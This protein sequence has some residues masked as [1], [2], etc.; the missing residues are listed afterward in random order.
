MTRIALIKI[1]TQR[2]RPYFKDRF[3]ENQTHSKLGG[4]E[5][6]C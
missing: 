1:E 4:T 5:K 2:R 6:V 3:L